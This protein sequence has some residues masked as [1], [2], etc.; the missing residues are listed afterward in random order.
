MGGEWPPLNLATQLARVRRVYRR[1]QRRAS[2]PQQPDVAQPSTRGTRDLASRGS[3]RPHRGQLATAVSPR[4]ALA[5]SS[6]LTAR[7]LR[8]SPF[9]D[10][11]GDT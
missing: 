2:R 7:R 9:R 10:G 1:Q 8:P 4:P 6:K 5:L 11:G 3:D